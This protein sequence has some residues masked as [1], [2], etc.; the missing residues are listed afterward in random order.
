MFK[1]LSIIALSFTLIM[2]KKNSTPTPA[3]VDPIVA[4]W[5]IVKETYTYN[6]GTPAPYVYNFP[7][8]SYIEFKKD[9]SYYYYNADQTAKPNNCSGTYT[10]SGSKISLV[11]C[12]ASS[13][14]GDI[15]VENATTLQINYP[16]NSSNA[17]I[18]FELSK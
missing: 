18:L 6:S 17:K 9:N 12:I 15:L 11:G 8:G 14:P 5:T 4:K 16:D 13:T 3:P 2:C 10:I 1:K 7:A